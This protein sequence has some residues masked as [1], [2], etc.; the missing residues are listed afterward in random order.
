MPATLTM[1][2]VALILAAL[3]VTSCARVNVFPYGEQD[4]PGTS[5]TP[6]TS[7]SAAEESDDEPFEPWADLLEDT[8][9]VEGLLRL[10]VKRDQ[11]L[12]LELAPEQLE[13]NYG[14][15]LHFSRGI[16]DFGAYDGLELADT[17]L[18]RFERV[19]DQ[20]NLVHRNDRFIADEGSPMAASME[21]NVG[22]SLLYV[23][24][25]ESRN[26]STHHVLID[27]TDFIASDY[28]GLTEVFKRA[29]GSTSVT[30]DEDRSFVEQVRGFPK[31]VEIDAAAHVRHR[32]GQLARRV[33]RRPAYERLG[34]GVGPAGI[35][36]RSRPT[37]LYGY[38]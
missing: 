13:T 38:P 35:C 15:V 3:L 33:G 4:R 37:R 14:L 18:I 6:S 28:P 23:A 22:H 9:P 5:P 12:Y 11:T 7:S 29:Y 31:N 20:I 34:A 25:I 17:R 2:F 19:G 36:P 26:D 21:D 32:R 10:H 30:F 8:R 24:D 16:G 1:R 27:V